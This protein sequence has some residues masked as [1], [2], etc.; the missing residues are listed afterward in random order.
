MVMTL[1][2]DQYFYLTTSGSSNLPVT[3]DEIFTKVHAYWI[4]SE[5][6]VVF[7]A[8]IEGD[9]RRFIKRRDSVD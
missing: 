5:L 1:V 9:D 6:D 2:N 8:D 3:S 7:A 4:G